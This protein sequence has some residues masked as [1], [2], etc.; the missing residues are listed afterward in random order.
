MAEGTKLIPDGLQELG[1]AGVTPSVY[2]NVGVFLQ[3]CRVFLAQNLTNELLKF[4]MDSINDH[5]VLPPGGFLL[6]DAG[7]NKGT[8]NTAAIPQGDGLWVTSVD[9]LPTSGS[10]YMSYWY[11]A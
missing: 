2:I 7:T 10:V 3:P 9:T 6:I 8:P 11:A 4:S 5:F 1:F